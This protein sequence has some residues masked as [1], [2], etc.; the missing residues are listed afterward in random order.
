MDNVSAIIKKYSGE[1][2][3]NHDIH[4]Q[5]IGTYEGVEGDSASV[6][7]ATAVISA[8]EKVP[9]NQSIAMT[10]SLSVRGHVLPV[11]GVTAKA[12]AAAETGLAEV[13]IPADNLGD[14]L[15]E[16][17]YEGK[18]RIFTVRTLLDVLKEALVAG[19]EKDKLIS[20]ISAIFV[21]DATEGEQPVESVPVQPAKIKGGRPLPR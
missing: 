18:I 14:V 4:I 11:G 20:K 2:I 21:P 1:D 17:R 12:E 19:P 9:V 15:L 16:P 5:F 10:G 7:I 3:S 6:S 8:F 13:I